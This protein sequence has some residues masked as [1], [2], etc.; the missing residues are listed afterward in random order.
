MSRKLTA[1]QVRNAIKKSCDAIADELNATLGSGECEPTEE[2]ECPCGQDLV[3]CDIGIG[4]N[5][6]AVELDPP[7]LF[8]Y[9]PNCGRRVKR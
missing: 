3:S 2:Y 5:G 8:N 4:P 1:E 6:G 9:C 7:I